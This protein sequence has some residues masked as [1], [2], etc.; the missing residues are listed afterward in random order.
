MEQLRITVA[1]ATL[2][3]IFLDDIPARRYGYELMEL[4]GF[5]SGKLYPLLGRLENAGWL[6]TETEDVDPSA[7][8]RPARR[9][10]RL[11]EGGAEQAR[12]ELAELHRKLSPRPRVAGALRPEGGLA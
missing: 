1:V 7:A 9:W 3:R 10:Y 5:A 8:G 4:T 12:Q 2:L 6:V 11:S